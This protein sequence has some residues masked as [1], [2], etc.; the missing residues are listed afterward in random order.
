MKKCNLTPVKKLNYSIQEFLLNLEIPVIFRIGKNAKGN[1]EIIDL[2]LENDMWFHI[3]G[4]PSCHVIAS[5]PDNTKELKSIIKKGALLCKQNSKYISQKN[6]P[7]SY[8]LIKN[9][10]KTEVVGSVLITN[11]KTIIIYKL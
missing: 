9:V 4:L 5:I 11:H 3:E 2:A 6:L 1:H 8:T 10:K 7:I